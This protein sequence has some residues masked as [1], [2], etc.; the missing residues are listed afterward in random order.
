MT[1]ARRVGE[2]DA[3]YLTLYT[4]ICIIFP[5]RPGTLHNS[6]ISIHYNAVDGDLTLCL[7]DKPT[8]TM[9]SLALSGAG[10]LDWLLRVLLEPIA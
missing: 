5:G 9:P 6:V 10:L 8:S 7:S 1:V 4:Q 3:L 2:R